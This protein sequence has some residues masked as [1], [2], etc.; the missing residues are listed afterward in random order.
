M[1]EREMVVWLFNPKKKM[2]K[3]AKAKPLRRKR[4]ADK[5]IEDREEKL[6]DTSTLVEADAEFMSEQ[7]LERRE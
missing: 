3:P 7:W 1:V 4:I 2:P 5:D 6:Q